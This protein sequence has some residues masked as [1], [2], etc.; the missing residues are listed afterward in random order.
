[1]KNFKSKTAIIL[2]VSVVAAFAAGYLISEFRNASVDESPLNVTGKAEDE[3]QFWT[4]SMHP[5]IRQPEPGQCP[6]CG[7]DLIPVTDEGEQEVAGAP[8]LKLSET[9]RQL[10]DVRTAQVQRKY[11]T[12]E[13]GMVGELD[14]DETKVASIS[15]RVP[16]R[17]DRMFVDFTGTR[18]SEGD[19]L[20]LLFSPE[21][22][23]A[24]REF[25]EA[26]KSW[27]NMKDS[28]IETFRESSKQL[29]ES[30]REKLRLW[31]ITEEQI[32]EIEERND[33]TEHMTIYSP[34][35]G[36]VTEKYK[37]EGDYVQT[38]SR[39]YEIA[40]L[41]QLWLKME[42]YESD[43]PFIR[44]GQEVTFE[45]I[46]HPGRTFK[47]TISF[48]DPFVDEK[49]RT[50]S[51]RVNVPNE[52]GLLKP[53]MYIKA[54][55]RAKLAAEGQIFEPDLSGK[56]ICSMHPEIVKD[57]PGT[58][59]ICGMPLV[60]AETLGY[61]GSQESPPA[62]PV[63]IPETAALV[64]G[65]RAV[66]Y[67]Q[68]PDEPGRFYGREIVL[69]PKAGKYYVVM[70]G[71]EEGET[72][73][74][75][76]N[77]KIDSAMQIMAKPSMMNPEDEKMEHGHAAEEM[78][79]PEKETTKE[80][81]LE[82]KQLMAGLF[83]PYLQIQKHLSL[84]DLESAIKAAESLHGVMENAEQQI[85]EKSLSDDLKKMF[86]NMKKSADRLSDSDGMETARTHFS[87]LSDS[88]IENLKTVG[89]PPNAKI[90]IFHCPMA[91]NNRGADWLQKGEE[92]ENPY[93]GSAMFRCGE[94]TGTIS[95]E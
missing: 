37:N 92:V 34:I 74:T 29:L 16:G 87:V 19:H 86:G 83:E 75:N 51:V 77:F 64:T 32:K 93:F 43:L 8:S 81:P 79:E 67:I 45:T 20:V 23:T 42:A 55:A 48:I 5:Q 72:I 73:V 59:D 46:A 49:T 10:A 9:A 15:A 41:S 89:L 35:T 56:W 57:E 12:A 88:M 68:K 91:F 1:M 17:I 58:C 30:A 11:I 82:A 66:V 71:V 24:Q 27:E 54:E 50:V 85:E 61:A 52:T 25:L 21:L 70:E 47:G 60:K 53:G 76:G 94:K 14:Y 2:I 38:G 84:D 95:G 63:V 62:A 18:V 3:I 80:Y 31:G 22:L 36:L 13:V 78:K 40:D 26:K 4:C 6:I 7:M 69:G 39:I 28:E 65:E 90:S 44:Y 33:L